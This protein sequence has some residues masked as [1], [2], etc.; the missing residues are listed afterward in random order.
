MRYE[1]APARRAAILSRLPDVGFVSISDLARDFAVSHM[2]IRRDLQQLE[3]AG[4]VRVVHGGVVRAGA[5][6]PTPGAA[7]DGDGRTR[8]A[9][10]AVEMVGDCDVIAID[11]GETPYKLARALPPTFR[12]TVI[13]HSVPV[14]SLLAERPAQHRLIAL[15]GELLHEQQAFVGPTAVEAATQ[16][17]VRTLFLSAAAIDA[18]GLYSRYAAEV[19][20]QRRLM[21]IADNVVL[22]ADRM[23]FCTSA[24]ARLG[25]LDRLTAVVTDRRPPS[26]IAAALTRCGARVFLEGPHPGPSGT[27]D[28]AQ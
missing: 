23:S 27:C 5:D 22:L 2:T 28:G 11:A 13:S 21:D 20:V 8:I 15:G 4:R 6:R 18:H 16:L 1:G 7:G 19:S 26:G 25:T 3:A 9:L 24:P 14:L 10:R 17:R 12:G